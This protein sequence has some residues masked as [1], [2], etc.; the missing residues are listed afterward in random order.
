MKALL[1]LTF[2]VSAYAHAEC[3][4]IEDP[5]ISEV[6]CNLELV[7]PAPT[8]SEW[9]RLFYNPSSVGL[10]SSGTMAAA[11]NLQ[12]SANDALVAKVEATVPLLDKNNTVRAAVDASSWIDAI[13]HRNSTG[14]VLELIRYRYVEG[15][16]Q[17]QAS[18][19]SSAFGTAAST[20]FG[21]N[22]Q[23]A[24][25]TVTVNIT[26]PGSNAV[27]ATLSATQFGQTLPSMR[28]RRGVQ[29]VGSGVLSAVFSKVVN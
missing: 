18:V 2:L 20:V 12:L 3:D 10:N 8:G 21:I 19:L 11:V 29:P 17:Q 24:A 5:P 27:I 22:T 13:V 23:Y 16:V 4:L 28:L 1:A 15:K 9:T 14:N 7:T 26:S 25:G 6:N